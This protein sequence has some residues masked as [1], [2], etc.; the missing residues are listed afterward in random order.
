MKWGIFTLI[1]T[2]NWPRGHVVTVPGVV[3][4]SSTAI[5]QF[6]VPVTSHP[7]SFSNFLTGLQPFVLTPT[8]HSHNRDINFHQSQLFYPCPVLKTLSGS[9]LPTW[10]E[11][12]A[13]PVVVRKWALFVQPHSHHLQNYHSVSASD[14]LN[15]ESKARKS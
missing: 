10:R 4:S 13:K 1:L 11:N 2:E 5:A 8:H 12:S 3:L 14:L 7:D 15:K 6:H 9:M